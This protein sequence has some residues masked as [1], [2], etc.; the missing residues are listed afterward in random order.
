MSRAPGGLRA[1]IFALAMAGA[2]AS[3][4]A[5][6]AQATPARQWEFAGGVSFVAP[7]TLGTTSAELLRPDGSSLTLFRA[8]NETGAGRGLEAHIGTAVA[9]RFDVEMSGIWMR[10]DA[11]AVISGDAESV[12]GVTLTETLTRF[13]IE[14]AAVWKLVDGVRVQWFV[15]GG[16]GWMRELSSDMALASDG[17][18]VNA[19]GGMKYWPGATRP[20]QG[21]FGL[22]AEVRLLGRRGG[23]A[24]DDGSFRL[25]P[26]VA[27]SALVRF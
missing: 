8:R 13:S 2:A 12:P 24:I 17:V 10:F 20:G 26:V 18:V 6:T 15:R 3:A 1:G 19:G 4:S 21:R 7:A 25:W 9:R 22:R 16:A 23:I 27:G 11:R 5:Q 14:G